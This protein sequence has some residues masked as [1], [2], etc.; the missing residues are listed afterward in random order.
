MKKLLFIIGLSGFHGMA[1]ADI[2]AVIPALAGGI[3]LAHYR[4]CQQ[5]RDQ[6]IVAHDASAMDAQIH[7]LQTLYATNPVCQQTQAI[8]AQT[9]VLP[10]IKAIHAVSSVT[11]FS[12]HYPADGI[13]AYY[14][15]DSQGRLLGLASSQ[16]PLLAEAPLLV[17]LLKPYPQGALQSQAAA[18]KEPVAIRTT[19]DG[20]QQFVFSQYVKKQ[21]CVACEILGIADVVYYFDEKGHYH[22]VQLSQ[23]IP[24]LI[25]P[26]PS[27]L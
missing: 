7:C 10:E 17:R 24:T 9:G 27:T 18:V 16:N 5:L 22:G 14:L 13:D 1:G 6:C 20:S 8:E 12:V 11:W 23:I 15:L 25:S 19:A 2:D 4:T 21:D 3:H 26:T